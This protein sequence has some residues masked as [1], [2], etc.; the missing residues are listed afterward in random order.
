MEG[1]EIESFADQLAWLAMRLKGL[2]DVSPASASGLLGPGCPAC[3]VLIR[4]FEGMKT[5]VVLWASL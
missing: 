3:E 2:G 4:P 5:R 1:G